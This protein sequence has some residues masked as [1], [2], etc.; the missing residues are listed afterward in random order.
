[1]K[2]GQGKT[3]C[4]PCRSTCGVR[5][6]ARFAHIMVNFGLIV[7]EKRFSTHEALLRG[8]VGNGDT[9]NTDADFSTSVI[10]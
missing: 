3:L 2:S 8:T 4:S 9:K 7:R 6:N 1:M 5:K 10:W